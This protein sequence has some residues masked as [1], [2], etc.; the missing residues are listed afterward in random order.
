MS[1]TINRKSERMLNRFA[2]VLMNGR[3]RVKDYDGK[4]FFI[5]GEDKIIGTSAVVAASTNRRGNI[6][7]LMSFTVGEDTNSPDDDQLIWLD[8]DNPRKTVKWF[9]RNGINLE[10]M[11]Y[12]PSRI[13]SFIQS[14]ANAASDAIPGLE[15]G[16]QDVY[17]QIGNYE[18]WA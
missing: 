2:K 9:S 6:T 10:P 15:G 3:S 8:V 7:A 5:S 11:Y 4:Y 13:Q 17:V 12:D 1:F 16:P 18:A 14:V